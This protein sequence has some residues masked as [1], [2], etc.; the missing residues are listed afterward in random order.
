M[1]SFS[2][3]LF[4]FLFKYRPV[5][6]E[7][8]DFALGAPWP[9]WVLFAVVAGIGAVTTLSYVRVRGKL[10]LR[11]R[12]LLIGVRI[13]LIAVLLFCLSRPILVL[14]TVV[15]QENFL[16]ILFDDSRSMQIADDGEV[17][18]SSFLYEHFGPEGS[19]LLDALSDRF[20]LRFFGFAETAER[21]ANLDEMSFTGTR[22]RLGPALEHASSELSAVPL[23]GLVVFTD[24]ADN[25]DTQLSETILQLRGQGIPVHAVGLGNRQFERDVEVTRVEAPRY[26][27]KGSSVAADVMVVHSGFG[28]ETVELNIEEDGRILSTKTIELPR[29]GETITTRVFFTAADA[30]PKVFS[31][32]I[33]SQAEEQVMQ[34]NEREVLIDVRT[35]PNRILYIEGEPRFEI[36]NLRRAVAED[37]TIEVVNLIITAEN[38]YYRLDVRDENE[39]LTGFPTTREELFQY[40]GVI[41][42][43]VDASYFTHDQLEMITEFVGDRGGGLL[44]LGG[45]HA[46]AEGGYAGTPIDNVLPVV[47]DTPADGD[48]ASN[49]FMVKVELTPF[50]RSHPVTQIA[51]SP[52]DSET[53]WPELPELSTVNPITDIKPGASTIL[54]GRTEGLDRLV[55]LASQRYGRGQSVA[56]TVQDSWLWQMHADIAVDDLTHE[57]FWRQLLRWLVNAAPERVVASVARDRV[58]PRETVEVTAEVVD[59]S[60]LSVNNAHVVAT[61]TSPAGEETRAP[62]EWTVERDGEY[63]VAFEPE[64]HGVYDVR[65]EVETE[66]DTAEAVSTHVQVADPVDEYFDAELQESLLGRLTDET[67]GGFYTPETVGSLPE[68]VRFTESGSTV[69]DELDLW[70][71]PVVFLLLVTLVTAEWSYRR[72][73]G[74]A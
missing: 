7:R 42:G 15:P 9:V 71:M 13:G 8:G 50:G 24:G 73:R 14:S 22:T 33:V 17:S 29:Q 51:D 32:R 34:N 37:E 23:A 59:S 40:S 52:E 39:V 72:W 35:R 70:D 38:K 60:Y 5:V 44:A 41:L 1:D 53:R 20:K 62:M 3:R 47:L 10:L 58:G 2:Q 63:K 49:V 28:G 27:L 54:A 19:E 43:N 74:L 55:V 4:E 21:V 18:R 16:G 36:G 12:G 64:E 56:F 31:F 30:G 25:S 65:V 61:L 6:F 11:D 45:R 69:Y 46:F 26:V 66:G 67:G 48:T 57:I 68:D